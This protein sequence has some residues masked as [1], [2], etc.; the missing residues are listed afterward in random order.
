MDTPPENDPPPDRPGDEY[1]I[2]EAQMTL[3]RGVTM[4]QKHRQPRDSFTE[5]LARTQNI[6]DAAT[7]DQ[8]KMTILQ[9]GGIG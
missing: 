8:R 9:M 7:E 3:Q 4:A 1:T 5:M 6:L 2:G